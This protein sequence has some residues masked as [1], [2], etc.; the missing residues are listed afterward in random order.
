MTGNILLIDSCDETHNFLSN[1]LQRRTIRATSSNEAIAAY[2]C[3]DNYIGLSFINLSSP[4]SLAYSKNTAI[5]AMLKIKNNVLPTIAFYEADKIDSSQLELFETFKENELFLIILEFEHLKTVLYN[6]EKL[7]RDSTPLTKLQTGGVW[8]LA[9]PQIIVPVIETDHHAVRILSLYGG[10]L[11][12][13]LSEKGQEERLKRYF[14]I[15]GL[16]LKSI[17]GWL[18]VANRYKT[19]RKNPDNKKNIFSECYHKVTKN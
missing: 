5:Y 14:A 1:N 4:D 17:M 16:E 8:A 6:M 18:V 7:Y 19:F 13:S 15:M 10:L 9:R 12:A 11:Q 3:T 2:S